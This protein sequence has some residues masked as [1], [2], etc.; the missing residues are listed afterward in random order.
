MKKKISLLLSVFLIL[1]G[2]SAVS[3]VPSPTETI[4]ISAEIFKPPIAICPEE[5]LSEPTVIDPL[6]YGSDTDNFGSQISEN[7]AADPSLQIPQNLT[8]I[9]CIIADS[10]TDDTLLLADTESS[11]IYRLNAKK[12]GHHILLDGQ[13]ADLSDLK[14]GM[15]ITVSW[16]GFIK[17]TW[18]AQFGSPVYISA[19]TPENG[20]VLDLCGFYLQ[21]LE[22]LWEMDS[23]LNS[24]ISLIGLDLSNAPGGLTDSQIAAIS[25]RFQELHGI[26]VINGTWEEL[27]KQGYIN[28]EELYWEDGCH[29]SISTGDLCPT[30]TTDSPYP[31]FSFDAQKWRSGLGAYFFMDCT[32]RWADG[33]W[34]GYDIGGEA[35]S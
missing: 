17:E 35:I 20:V 10:T 2:C 31:G 14:D 1:S 32:P 3:A 12:D 7:P 24:D 8:S 13:P 34:S 26:E 4:C 30:P 9:T 15:E 25:C 28:K 27:C 29:F 11:D 21:V 18:P 22:D 16:E 33:T 19:N 6:P 23:A 5:P